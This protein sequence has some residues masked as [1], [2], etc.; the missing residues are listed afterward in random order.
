MASIKRILLVDPDN[1]S[2]KYLA[3]AFKKAGYSVEVANTGKEGLVCAWRDRPH[4]I[5]IDPVFSDIS[6]QEFIQKLRRDNRTSKRKIIA[7]SSLTQPDHIQAA[8]NLDF[9][10]YLPKEKDA[11]PSLLDVVGK[12]L[13]GKPVKPISPD[14]SDSQ[15]IKAAKQ[16]G[17]LMVFLSAKG[18]TGTSSICANMAYMLNQ[19]DPG[20]KIVVADLVLPIGSIAPI[21]GYE[22]ELNLVKV[23]QMSG[24]EAS[25]EYLSE[26][27]PFI[28]EWNFHLLAGAPDPSLASEMDVSRIPL[29]INTLKNINDYVLID[30]G[31]SLSRISLPIITAADLI[32]IILSLDQATVTLTQRVM[33]YLQSKGVKREHIYL[34]INRAVGLEGLSKREVDKMLGIEITGNIPHIGGTF[35]LAN[36]AHQPVPKR[37]PDNIVGIALREIVETLIKRMETEQASD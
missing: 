22:G 19:H 6:P 20:K 5:V 3:T 16:Q 33:E 2:I 9:D 26:S 8:I 11:L 35:S 10:Y 21:V 4:I 27:L 31:R 36:N 25:P 32:I 24:S 1:I 14:L 12:L 29:H 17:K 15:A 37:Y 23:S 13:A 28:D 18:G 30:L 7:L 34:L